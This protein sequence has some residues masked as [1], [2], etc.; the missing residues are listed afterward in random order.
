MR[1]DDFLILLYQNVTLYLLSLLVCFLIMYILFRKLVNGIVDPM[2]YTLVMAVFANTIPLFLIL[3]N[4][5]SFS[6]F[7]FFVLAETF[8]WVGFLIGKPRKLVLNDII[9]VESEKRDVVI[10]TVFWGLYILLKLLTYKFVG[11]P[12]LMD[13]SRLGV[14]IGSNGLGALDRFSS[15][16]AFVSSYFVFYLFD[17]KKRLFGMIV[18]IS[19]IVFSVLSAAKSAILILLAGYFAFSFFK[20]RIKV[21]MYKLIKYIPFFLI[22]PVVILFQQGASD[23]V[24]ASLNFLIRFIA[25]GDV[26]YMSFPDNVIDSV[27]IKDKVTYFFSGILAPLRIVDINNLDVNIGYQLNW[28]VQNILEGELFGPNSRPTILSWVFFKWLGIPFNF[29]L[30]LTAGILIYLPIRFL[31]KGTLV[32]IYVGYVYYV[33]QSFV[34]DT[35]L[36]INVL[37]DVIVNTLLYV[38]I[39]AIV[40]KLNSNF[41]THESTN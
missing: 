29:L 35:V 41:V 37:F 33:L 25:N 12:L 15:L 36:G 22:I 9:L 21:D 8:F 40:Y 18:L 4:K 34:G 5:I 17:K 28:S 24:M 19:I 13:E 14:F 6:Y 23:Y 31:P 20:S 32:Y 27:V 11:V 7:L 39:I 16:P 1:I 26:Y 2:L 30:G 10:L 38:S 3:T